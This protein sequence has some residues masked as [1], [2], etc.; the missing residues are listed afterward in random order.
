MGKYTECKRALGWRKND[1]G[2]GEHLQHGCRRACLPWFVE[3]LSCHDGLDRCN[4]QYPD[5]NPRGMHNLGWSH[6][7]LW[8]QSA[9]V[10]WWQD[11]R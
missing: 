7:D 8:V 10:L 4:P 5:G 3:T 9:G 1:E 6:S 11:R 2:G